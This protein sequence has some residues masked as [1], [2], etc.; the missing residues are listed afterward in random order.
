M[1]W[2]DDKDLGP[3]EFDEQPTKW[4]YLN[5]PRWSNNPKNSADSMSASE[6]CEDRSISLNPE[7][8]HKPCGHW[9]KREP[10]YTI[11][12]TIIKLLSCGRDNYGQL[13][14]GAQDSVVNGTDEIVHVGED[15]WSRVSAGY[16]FSIAIKNDGTLWSTGYN[17]YGQLGLGDSTTRSEWEQVGSDSNWA[18]VSC[19][20]DFALAI[21]TDGTMYATGY[22]DVGQLGLN[23]KTN[24]N[25]FT[26]VGSDSN[27]EKVECGYRHSIASKTDDSLWSTGYN[28]Y[29]QLGLGDDVDRDEFEQIG[30]DTNW[31]DFSTGYYH[32]AAIK[33]TGT[34][35][36][37]GRD[38]YGEC[39][40]GGNEAQ[41]FTQIGSDNTW[42]D[43]ACGDYHTIAIKSDETMWGTGSDYYGQLGLNN[44]ENDFVEYLEFTQIT[45]TGWSKIFC[46][47]EFSIAIKSDDTVWGSGR[48]EYG[49]F[50]SGDYGI[51]YVFIEILF[52]LLSVACGTRHTLVIKA[53]ESLWVS[54]NNYNG[55]LGVTENLRYTDILTSLEGSDWRQVDTWS[56]HDLAVKQ[57]ADYP[58]FGCGD[59][60]SG[61][62]GTNDYNSNADYN[63]RWKLSVIP[64]SDVSI[65]PELW[66]A[67]AVCGHQ[68][69][70]VLDTNGNIWTF[71]DNTYGQLALD[72]KID[73]WI[74][75][76][77][78]SDV[79]SFIAAGSYATM[80]ILDSDNSLWVCGRNSGTQ[81]GQLGTNDTTDR[82]ELTKITTPSGEWN[83]VSI[84]N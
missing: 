36:T 37:T 25:T 64:I 53:D 71:G 18:E 3:W 15:T 9:H 73:R 7:D 30:S 82:D 14:L 20:Y 23:H 24:K 51:S 33:S 5:N 13:G 43:I 84:G 29:G 59:N 31:S 52:G 58:V 61:Q 19:G 54:G 39:G 8:T 68:H 83:Q 35:W 44:D 49:Q 45:G 72:D 62:L 74:P 48:N 2:K 67:N 6:F 32:A 81:I 47:A 50:G 28:H 27:W 69:S 42:H 38:Q 56:Y 34:L 26:Q 21:K 40:L 79:Y 80:A 60:L 41:S 12:E 46:G 57:N 70:V 10:A 66:L 22:N 63:L 65:N 78:S 11:S 4:G 17:N 77:V 55:S 76:Q 75:T 16:D 1:S